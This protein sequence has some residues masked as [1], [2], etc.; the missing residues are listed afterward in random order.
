MEFLPSFTSASND[1]SILKCTSTPQKAPR[2]ET[3][4]SFSSSVHARK[5]CERLSAYTYPLV[6]PVLI[7]SPQTL[8]NLQ[9]SRITALCFPRTE[10]FTFRPPFHMGCRGPSF[11]FT[12][13]SLPE[14]RSRQHGRWGER[15]PA[16][17]RIRARRGSGAAAPAQLC[18]APPRPAPGKPRPGGPTCCCTCPVYCSTNS[19][20]RM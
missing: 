10:I 16:P 8:E 7:R 1:H 17:R 11:T 18:P 6:T 9:R 20:K 12:A 19:A 4:V 15:R 13:R 14:P 5:G 2:E 3:A